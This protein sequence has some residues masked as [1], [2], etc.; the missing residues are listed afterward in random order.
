MGRVHERV[1]AP[2]VPEPAVVLDQLAHDGALRVPHGETA[3]EHRREAQQVE[4]GR[5]LAMVAFG[6]LLQLMEMVGEGLLG[7]PGRAVDALQHRPLLVAAPVRA[8]HLLQL[9]MAEPARRR[10]VRTD[11]HVDEIVGVAVH[12]DHAVGRHLGG[13]LVVD[14]TGGRL[15]LLDDLDL[16][17]LV[18]E[19]LLRVGHRHLRPRERLVGLDDLAHPRLDPAEVVVAE[20][21]S[22]REFEV[23][24]EAV[25]DGRA[26]RELGAREQL[27]D[28][29]GHH[30]RRRVAQ[31]VPAG[32]GVARDDRHDITVVELGREIDLLAVDRRGDGRLPQPAADGRGQVERRGGSVELTLGAIGERDRDRGHRRPRIRRQRRR[33]TDVRFRTP[34]DSIVST[35]LA[36]RP[37]IVGH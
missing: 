1:A 26:D 13:V 6:R 25:L 33:P 8:G 32:V 21:G 30:V 11:A 17:G 36:V 12:A 3:A 9:E 20:R 23:V 16:V 15:D 18:G 22:A 27:R 31:H 24:V 28:G 4:L 19:E 5:Q 10:H 35:R 29:L 34:A 37:A 7:L 2:L 14:A